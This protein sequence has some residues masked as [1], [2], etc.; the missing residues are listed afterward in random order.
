MLS[1][2]YAASGIV[3][4]GGASR[5]MGRDK[6]LLELDGRS[7]LQRAAETV[8]GVCEELVIAAADRPPQHL[9]GLTPI[10]AP[11]PPGATGPLAGLEAGLSV[12]AHPVAL[13]VACDMPFLNEALLWHLLDSFSGCDAVVPIIGGVPQPL[14][15]VYGREC[16]RTVRA[17]LH[18]RARSMREL[19]PRLRVKYVSERR[20]LELDGAGLSCF[21]VNWPDDYFEARRLLPELTLPAAAA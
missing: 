16:L 13:A 19:L 1:R 5:R 21:N 15:A 18:L 7:L 14:H 17:L 11:D 12:A 10:W 9:P 3:L 20:C 4:A 8:S 2:R 6:A